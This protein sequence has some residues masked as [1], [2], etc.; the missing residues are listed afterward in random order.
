MHL[1]CESAEYFLAKNNFKVFTHPIDSNGLKTLIAVHKINQNI[2]GFHGEV[3]IVIVF[4]N[5]SAK[6]ITGKLIYRSL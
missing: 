3:R 2:I 1:L 6:D 4:S 5:E